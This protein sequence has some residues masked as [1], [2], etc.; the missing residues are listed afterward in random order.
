M[1]KLELMVLK[2]KKEIQEKMG[3]LMDKMELMDKRV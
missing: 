2:D 3:K 1:E